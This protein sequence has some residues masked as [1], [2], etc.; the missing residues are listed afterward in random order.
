MEGSFFLGLWATD[1]CAG[2]GAAYTR[3]PLLT[4]APPTSCVLFGKVC[5]ALVRGIEGAIG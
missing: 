3:L 4:K 5:G 2:M 1:R